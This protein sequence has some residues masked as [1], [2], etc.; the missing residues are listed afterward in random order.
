MQCKLLWIKKVYP[1]ILPPPESSCSH[2]A[3]SVDL[4][5]SVWLARPEPS[6]PPSAGSG[7]AADGPAHS[8]GTPPLHCTPPAT[9]RRTHVEICVLGAITLSVA[10]EEIV[11]APYTLYEWPV[12]C[13]AP[14][15]ALCLSDRPWLPLV[16][17]DATSPAP[18]PDPASVWTL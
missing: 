12:Q 17:P 11:P 7:T 1:N 15:S 9:T 8:S 5:S 6:S 13:R 18:A 2:C 4:H 14:V 16:P 10:V 3:L